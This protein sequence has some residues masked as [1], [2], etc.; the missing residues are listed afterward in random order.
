[1]LRASTPAKPVIRQSEDD[2]QAAILE[3]LAYAGVT[4]RALVIHIPN[5]GKRS[6][7]Y[8]AKLKAMGLMPG[9]ADLCLIAPGGQSHFIE[10][11]TEAGSLSRAQKDFRG[12]CAALGI[13]WALARSPEEALRSADQ[14]GLVPKPGAA[15]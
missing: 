13:P 11:K 9:A 10:V 8:G 14:W 4:R 7:V 5:Q 3:A 1:M 15:A 6:P 12:S 2:L